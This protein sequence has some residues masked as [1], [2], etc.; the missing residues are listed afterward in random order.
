M[1]KAR[2]ACKFFIESEMSERLFFPF[3][4]SRFEFSKDGDNIEE[5]TREFAD[6][7]VELQIRMAQRTWGTVE[8]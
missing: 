8:D 1:Y 2:G 4:K 6:R 7:I 3:S 5:E